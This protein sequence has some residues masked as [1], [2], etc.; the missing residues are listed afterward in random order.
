MGAV[1]VADSELEAELR[2]KDSGL[3]VV[4]AKAETV[5]VAACGCDDL[6]HEPRADSPAS[7]VHQHVQVPH[8]TGPRL[9]RITIHTRRRFAPRLPKS[10]Q[11]ICR[12][13]DTC[14]R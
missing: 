1:W 5:E 2:I 4:G 13:L 14:S 8:A 6:A 12:T 3:R 9:A 7:M 11:K 10:C